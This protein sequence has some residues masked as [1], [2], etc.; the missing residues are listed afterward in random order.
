MLDPIMLYL[1][2]ISYVCLGLILFS[3]LGMVMYDNE[4]NQ[5]EIEF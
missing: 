3:F 2:L 4:S 5:W 1:I